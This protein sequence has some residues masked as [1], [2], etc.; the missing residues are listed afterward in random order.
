MDLLLTGWG[1]VVGSQPRV[2]CTL[3]PYLPVGAHKRRWLVRITTAQRFRS[4]WALLKPSG[5]KK[6]RGLRGRAGLPLIARIQSH[7][8]AGDGA[9]R[10][11]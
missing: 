2:F 9:F 11:P 7:I 10:K 3:P 8:N 5:P 4:V 1:L 6:G